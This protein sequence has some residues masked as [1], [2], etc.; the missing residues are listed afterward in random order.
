MYSAPCFSAAA[1]MT[2]TGAQALTRN[3][4]YSAGSSSRPSFRTARLIT[5]HSVLMSRTSSTSE[6]QREVTQAKGHM[7][8]NQKSALFV[9]VSGTRFS[10]GS[11]TGSSHRGLQAALATHGAVQQLGTATLPADLFRLP[12]AWSSRSGGFTALN[13]VGDHGGRSLF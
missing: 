10:F 1:T 3:S 12:R 2:R 9:I 4:L 13:V 5:C 8:S 6:I 11:Q 7:G